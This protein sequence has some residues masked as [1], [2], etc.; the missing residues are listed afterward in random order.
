MTGEHRAIITRDAPV[1]ISGG[2]VDGPEWF[3][4]R[5]V[6]EQIATIREIDR[7]WSLSDVLDANEALDK[8]AARQ[9]RAR[10]LEA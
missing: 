3:V 5:L 1:D 10:R 9:Q 2:E 6:V 4:W 7:H 8:W